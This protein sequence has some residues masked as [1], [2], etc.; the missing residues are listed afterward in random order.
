MTRPDLLHLLEEALELKPNTL[1]GGGKL[2]DLEGWDSMSA[3][4]VIAILDKKCGLALPG[5]RVAQCQ[6]VD[7]LL[8][9]VNGARGASAA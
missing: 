1:T 4:L 8:G 7:D 2:R 6:T 5:G 3:L 9:L